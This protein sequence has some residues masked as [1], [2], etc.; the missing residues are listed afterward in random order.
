MIHFP[1]SVLILDSR[2]FHS[3]YREERIASKK[4]ETQKVQAKEDEAT[5]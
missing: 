4:A 2:S 3:S 5:K 1:R